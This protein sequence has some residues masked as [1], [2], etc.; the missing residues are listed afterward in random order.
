V[1]AVPQDLASAQKAGLVRVPTHIVSVSSSD[2]P[3]PPPR[4]C[5]LLKACSA[6]YCAQDTSVG[7]ST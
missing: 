5:A 7:C 6:R 4:A 1:P 2:N 3:P